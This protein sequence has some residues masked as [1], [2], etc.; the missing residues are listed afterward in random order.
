MTVKVRGAREQYI[1]ITA[2]LDKIYDTVKVFLWYENVYVIKTKQQQ[3]SILDKK[4]EEKE[5]LMLDI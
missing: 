1:S 3:M 2:L 4:Y 5:L